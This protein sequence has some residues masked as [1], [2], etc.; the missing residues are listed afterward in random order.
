MTRRRIVLVLLAAGV[1]LGASAGAGATGQ[2]L[3]RPDLS[4]RAAVNNYLI[5]IG[6]NPNGVVVQR[7]ARVYAGP[8]CPG[9]A[10]TCTRAM[11]VVQLAAVQNKFE[12]T[13]VAAQSVGTDQGA[14]A[15]FIMQGG[16]GKN[17][18]TCSLE[19]TDTATPSSISQTCSID[20]TNTEN[21]NV[22]TIKMVIGQTGVEGAQDAHQLAHVVQSNETGDNFST[23]EQRISQTENTADAGCVAESE[24]ASRISRSSRRR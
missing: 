5:S 6:V 24:A 9:A 13:P 7:G 17:E 10:W 14:N 12:C 2:T 15:C 11:Q 21:D 19:N 23:I 22:A 18:A 3:Q 1:A 8:N 16:P 4:S 20:Q